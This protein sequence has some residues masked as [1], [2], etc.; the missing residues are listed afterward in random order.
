MQAGEYTTE[1][2][3]AMKGCTREEHAKLTGVIK[4]THAKLRQDFKTD[5]K[6]EPVWQ[7]HLKDEKMRREYSTAMYSLA[8]GHWERPGAP[9]SRIMWCKNTCLEFFYNDGLKKALAKDERRRLFI[10]EAAKRSRAE[11]GEGSSCHVQFEENFSINKP[12]SRK[13]IDPSTMSACTP[14]YL[15]DVGSCYNPF[16]DFSEF[17]TVAIDISPAM[18]S[19]HQ[20]DFVHLVPSPPL[21]ESVAMAT[22]IDAL[23][24]TI[25]TL[26]RNA[27]HVVVFSL[28]L[29][30]L[31]SPAPRWRCCGTAHALLRDGGLLVVVT[32]DSKHVN[33]NAPQMRAWRAAVESL[34]FRRW[35]YEKLA[36]LHCMAF[37]K[38]GAQRVV[39]PVACRRRLRGSTVVELRAPAGKTLWT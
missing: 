12:F 39:R 15:L 11:R 1:Y 19:V 2:R 35:R 10:E 28:L 24:P 13:D 8:T 16:K 6:W 37:R 34:G 17:C 4:S 21:P 14:L 33:R 20:C 5:G 36:H 3:A 29:E 7:E 25:A 38:T 32:P 22:Y 23:P 9:E 30:Y 31:P 18:E 27:F 26:P